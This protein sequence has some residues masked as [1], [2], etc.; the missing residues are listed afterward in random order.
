M[1]SDIFMDVSA[2][3][4]D[5]GERHGVG[6]FTGK[7]EDKHWMNTPGAIYCSET[8]NSGTGP[9]AAPNNVLIDAYGYGFVFRQPVNRYELRQTLQAA[10][11]DPFRAY[12]ADGDAHWS[13]REIRAWWAQVPALEREIE[14]W[15]SEQLALE[16]RK[17]L[18]M[19]AGLL[20][21]RDYFRDGMHQYLR[22]YAFFL[23]EGHVPASHDRL[24]DL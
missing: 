4:A 22:I 5:L 23:E 3:L 9:L 7:W 10:E 12:G 17:D 11:W 13:L 20:H 2:A 19:F 1:Y 14:R 15:Y 16:H 18:I 6:R 24:P 8:D 21:W